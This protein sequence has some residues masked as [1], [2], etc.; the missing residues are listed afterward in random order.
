M[1]KLGISWGPTPTTAENDCTLVVSCSG[2][3]WRKLRRARAE[4]FSVDL[5]TM[6]PLTA[7]H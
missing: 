5:I 4:L 7:R 6:L 2:G 1:R 3:R